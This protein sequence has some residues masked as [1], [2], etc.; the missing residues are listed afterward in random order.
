MPNNAARL[1]D[2]IDIYPV[3]CEALS[4]GRSDIEVLDALIAGGAKIVQLRDKHASKRALYHKALTFRK[5]TA[6]AGM[7]LI[8]NDYID[9]ALAVAADGVHLGQDD[10]P[11]HAARSIAHDLLIGI[12]THSRE[13]AL[14]AQQAGADYINIGPIFPTATKSTV[15]SALGTAVIQDIKPDL[16]IPFTVMGGIKKRNIDELLKCGAQRMAMV[17]EITQ[18][19]DIA[20]HVRWLRERICKVKI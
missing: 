5:K 18:A 15:I 10:M 4:N 9:I 20:A 12:S 19:H 6:A 16:R 2:A 13:E 8:I 3:T 1:F 11:L 14:I 7:L 17:T